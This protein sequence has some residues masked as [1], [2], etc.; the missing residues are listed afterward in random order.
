MVWRSGRHGLWALVLGIAS[1]GCGETDRSPKSVPSSPSN[2]GQGGGASN[3]TPAA[4]GAAGAGGIDMSSG[5]TGANSM[6]GSGMTAAGGTPDCSMFNDASPV[7]VPVRIV[8]AT[9][10]PIH[11]GPKA[12]NCAAEPLYNVTDHS[13]MLLSPPSSCGSCREVMAGSFGCS[14]VCSWTPAVTLQPGETL[15]QTWLGLASMGVDALPE[16]CLRSPSP[17]ESGS[18]C[19]RAVAQSP[20]EFTFSAKAGT[21]LACGDPV[22]ASCGACQPN[23]QGGCITN[24]GV[25]PLPSLSAET[26]VTLS[27]TDL[28][29]GPSQGPKAELV[30]K[31]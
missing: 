6:G 4:G 3:E 9:Q 22:S 17:L 1:W 24:Q 28:T 27:A 23:A 2:V 8:N 5:G 12:I 18:H 15:D 30:F 13:G 7:A 20:G 19:W 11:L 31:D 26:T 16:A 21:A 14:L 25:V 10:G 29:A